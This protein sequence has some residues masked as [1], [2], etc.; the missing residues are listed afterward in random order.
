MTDPQELIDRL[1]AIVEC[2]I[3]ALEKKNKL[4]DFD[5][6]NI[7]EF[8]K[9]LMAAKKTDVDVEAELEK[10]ISKLPTNQLRSLQT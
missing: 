3:V 7:A 2:R 9:I 5:C 4:T 8:M 10:L 1:M 6:R